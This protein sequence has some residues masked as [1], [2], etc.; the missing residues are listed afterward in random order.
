M[1]EWDRSGPARD[2]IDLRAIAGHGHKLGSQTGELGRQRTEKSFL[3]RM[4]P[5]AFLC[6]LLKMPIGQRRR[7]KIGFFPI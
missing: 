3:L 1:C 5:A 4:S 7:C 6:L 2:Y